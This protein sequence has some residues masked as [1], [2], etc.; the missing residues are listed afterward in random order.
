MA[1]HTPTK[2][3]ALVTSIAVFALSIYLVARF[4]THP[5]GGAD[6]QFVEHYEWIPSLGISYH[7]EWTVSPCS[8][9]LL[10]T[11]LSV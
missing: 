5:A 7:Q 4:Q 2:V 3:T 6:F 1:G 9:V 8:L 11:L 10:T